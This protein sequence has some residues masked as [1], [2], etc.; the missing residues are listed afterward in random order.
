MRPCQQIRPNPAAR[1]GPVLVAGPHVSHTHGSVPLAL[2]VR[3][4]WWCALRVA[5]TTGHALFD[6][7]MQ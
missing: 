6:T 7:A 1:T 2:G 3:A 5:E 4:R